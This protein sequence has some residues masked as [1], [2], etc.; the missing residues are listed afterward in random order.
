MGKLK[1]KGWKKKYYANIKQ[2]K[3]GVA[4][5]ISDRED[6]RAWKMISNK[7][8]IISSTNG[9]RKTG[10]TAMHKRVKLGH[11]LIVYTKINPK[12]IKDLSVTPRTEHRQ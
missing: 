2:M 3:A 5:L 6:L 12:W 11:F 7:S 1:I 8:S 4:L 10:Q 9:V